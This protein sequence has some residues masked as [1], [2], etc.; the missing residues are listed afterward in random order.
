MKYQSRTDGY[1]ELIL[2]DESLEKL[3]LTVARVSYEAARI[4]SGFPKKEISDE[5]LLKFINLED[6]SLLNM[7]YDGSLA[8]KTSIKRQ[9]GKI[10]FC[11]RQFIMNRPY[12]AE[13]FLDVV[14]SKIE[15]RKE[16]KKD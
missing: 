9:D 7:D 10:L 13:T 16:A 6:E 12:S 8:L 1:T 15:K 2:E 3:L 4:E 5:Y 11:E 14:I